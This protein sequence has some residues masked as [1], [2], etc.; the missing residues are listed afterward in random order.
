MRKAIGKH[1]RD[2]VAIIALAILALVATGL[3]LANQQAT[4]PNW[5]PLLGSDRFELK[6]SFSS[7]QAVTPG[8][9]QTVNIAGVKVGSIASVDLENGD[10]VVTM[11]VDNKYAPLIH[12]DATL[13]LRPRTGLA[14]MTIDLDPG[15]GHQQVSEG[16]TIPLAQTQ[17][18]VQPDQVLAS[19]DG[20]TR[21]FLQ[22]LLA[23]GAQGLGHNGV[24]FSADLRRLD[25]FARDLS[26]INGALAVRRQN[27]ARVIHNFGSLSQELATHDHDLQNFVTS[28]NSVF[29]SFA[30]QQESLRQSLQELPSTLQATRGALDSSNRFSLQLAPALTRLIPAAKALGP[31]LH[32]TQPFFEQTT[33]PI[34]DQIRPFTRQV[35]PPLRHLKQAAAPLGKTT[36]NLTSALTELNGIFNALA[37]N[38]SGPDEGFLFWLAWLNHDVNALFSLQDANGPDPRAYT[39]LSCNTS[40]LAEFVA[41]T[42]LFLKTLLQTTNL[43]SS[44]LIGMHGGCA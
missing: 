5:V 16:S 12:P 17:P 15:T 37:Y 14:D 31:A 38:P 30:R 40:Q 22:L 42:D 35:Q 9:G 11:E 43:P 34:R 3:I 27:I 6:A 7:A 23:G 2:F 44:A 19:L 25:P 10:A 20:D 8:Q 4:L 26:R 33:A 29:A 21:G 36:T 32:Q 1:L 18:N 28:S 24:K 39:L 41:E 13:L